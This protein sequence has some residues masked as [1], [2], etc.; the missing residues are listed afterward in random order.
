MHLI[1]G[2]MKVKSFKG[3][4]DENF[5]YLAWCE[6]TMSGAIIDPSVAPLEIFKFINNNNI[7]LSKILITHTHADHISYLSDFIHQYPNIKIYGYINTRKSLSE[8]FY[9]LSHNDTLSIGE[10]ILTALYTP[11][12]YDDCLCYWDNINNILFTGDTVFVGRSGRTINPY[13]NIS[14][15]YNSI[16]NIIL[17]LP[18]KTIIYSGHDY[19]HQPTITISE[20][21]KLS[22]FFSCKSKY[23][24]INIMKK[25]ESNRK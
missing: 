6:N 8:N 1:S 3:G 10:I 20:N 14:E 11:G 25:F 24:F 15:L 13:S 7:I 2:T 4:F 16:Y 12:H 19:G 23:E 18:K 22:S 21:I 17:K 9:G 5:C